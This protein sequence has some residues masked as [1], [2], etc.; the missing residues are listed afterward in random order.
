MQRSILIQYLSE[1]YF[2]NGIPKTYCKECDRRIISKHQNEQKRELVELKGGKCQRCG[3]DK[4]IGALDFHHLDPSQKSFSLA[5][6]ITKRISKDIL[7][8]EISKCILICSNC[9]GEINDG[10]III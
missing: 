2:Y 4:C 1:F 3:Y 5:R 6:G 9:H 10:I 8:K 7:I